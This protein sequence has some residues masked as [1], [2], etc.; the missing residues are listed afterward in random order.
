M[1]FYQSLQQGKIRSDNKYD[2]ELVSKQSG[3]AT[4]LRRLAEKQIISFGDQQLNKI[5]MIK[6]LR[7]QVSF[8]PSVV[9]EE[10][11]RLQELLD[12]VGFPLLRD[13]KAGNKTSNAYKQAS[14]RFLPGDPRRM[15]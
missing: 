7:E 3:T 11:R 4:I 15:N 5:S 13:G 10:A 1:E 9:N 2:S 12:E 6:E 14:G 8:A